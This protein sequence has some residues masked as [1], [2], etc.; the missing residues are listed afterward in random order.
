M[1]A[2]YKIDSKSL[3]EILSDAEAL[4]KSKIDLIDKES[5][6]NFSLFT[7]LIDNKID[8]L[9]I[10]DQT[11]A[12]L[13]LGMLPPNIRLELLFRASRDGFKAVPYHQKVD[14]Q[15]PHVVLIKSKEH[16]Q[17]FGASTDIS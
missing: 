5:F 10:K 7:P 17:I 4:I 9:I 2:S 15:G 3:K 8:S 12:K 1:D 13:F 11:I 14:N 16:N 6:K